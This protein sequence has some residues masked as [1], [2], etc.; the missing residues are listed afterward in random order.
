LFEC[1]GAVV[2]EAMAAGLPV[3]ATAWGG[4]LDYLDDSCGVLVSPDSRAALVSGFAEAIVRLARSAS[5]RDQMG[6]AGY[7]RVRQHFDWQRK[8]DRML[9]LYSSVSQNEPAPQVEFNG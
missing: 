3:I 5:L 9:E 6:Q 2:L 8:I 4:P 1:G 7:E